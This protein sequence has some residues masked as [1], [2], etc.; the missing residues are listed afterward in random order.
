MKT[1]ISRWIA[2]AASAAVVSGVAAP[3]HA[4]DA[5]KACALVTPAEL[6][7]ALGEKVT[8]KP[9][10]GMEGVALCSGTTP[11]AGVMLRVAMKSSGSEDAAKEGIEMARKMGAQVD[12]KTFGPMT[13]STMIPSESLAAHGFNTTCSVTKGASVAA[14]EVTTKTKA[15][16]V[17]IEHMKALA[18]KMAGRF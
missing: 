2:L 5:N 18:E 16:M 10:G 12:V 7:A 11:K 15:E 14:I 9:Q 17:S 6:E 8:L 1:R 4:A 3:V 13:C